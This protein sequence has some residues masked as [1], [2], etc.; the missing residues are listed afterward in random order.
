MEEKEKEEEKVEKDRLVLEECVA[1][2]RSHTRALSADSVGDE[3]F[4]QKMKFKQGPCLS[5][6]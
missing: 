3:T 4:G 1:F 2:H 6:T 5:R